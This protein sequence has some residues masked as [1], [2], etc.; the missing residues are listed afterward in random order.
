MRR[1]ATAELNGD[2][3]QVRPASVPTVSVVIPTYNRAALIGET[4][5]SVQAQQF[6]SWECIVVDDGSTDETRAVV[7]LF[8]RADPR[9]RYVWQENA[10]ATVARNLGLALAVGKYILFV[11]SDDHL[12]EDR[13]RWQVEQL[14]DN[15]DAVL[16]YGNTLICHTADMRT[17][18]VYL[19]HMRAKPSGWAFEALLQCSAIYAPLVRADAL[20]LAGGFDAALPQA[21]EDWDMWLRL[22]RMGRILFDER[23]HLYYRA[24]AGG[25]SNDAL[26]LYRGAR[27]VVAKNLKAEPLLRRLRLRRAAMAYLRHA[28][29]PRLLQEA[30]AASEAEQWHEAR[31]LWRTLAALN[32]GVLLRL[33]ILLNTLWAIVPLTVEPPWRTLRRR[34]RRSLRLS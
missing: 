15:P 20:R 21:G 7:D 25:I 29:T 4:L 23:I 30:N 34:L 6:D 1:D 17:G 19:E 3:I 18:G 33:R 8:V 28:Y 14:D 5:H 22:S 24:H 12:A 10:T 13:L 2:T 27:Q 26:R 31:L 11:D 9:I 32:P 16:V